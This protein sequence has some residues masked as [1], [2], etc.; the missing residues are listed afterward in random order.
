MNIIITE[1]Q[2]K[3]IIEH[4]H[5]NGP[6]YFNED[7]YLK[8]NDIYDYNPSDEE[9]ERFLKMKYKPSSYK[10]ER[11][12]NDIPLKKTGKLKKTVEIKKEKKNGY[13]FLRKLSELKGYG[14]IKLMIWRKNIEMDKNPIEGA[15]YKVTP[16]YGDIKPHDIRKYFF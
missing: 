7:P 14:P 10:N 9:I 16:D 8:D 4:H 2:F 3:C 12:N 5:Y 6:Y 11:P 13:A 1:Q 15:K